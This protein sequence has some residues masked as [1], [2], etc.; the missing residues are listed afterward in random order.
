MSSTL[1][2]CQAGL[3]GRGRDDLRRKE[4]R[5]TALG[6]EPGHHLVDGIR[7]DH[8]IPHVGQSAPKTVEPQ[9]IR[10]WIY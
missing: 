1:S 10:K 3:G 5:S 2:G 7:K 4:T 6:A 8:N 9:P